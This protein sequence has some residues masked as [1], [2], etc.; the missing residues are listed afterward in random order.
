MMQY[1]EHFLFG[2]Y[3]YIGLSVFLIGSLVRFERGQYTWRSGSSQMLR[4]RQLRWGSNLFHI[5]I[6]FLFFG[7][8]VG[9][10]TPH[11][12]YEH[13]ITAGAKQMVAVVSG[14]T[15][16]V[17]CFIGLTLLLHRRLTDPRIRATSSPMDIAIL[18]VLWLQLVLGLITLPFSVQHSDGSTML[19]LSE[20]AQ[21]IVTFRGGAAELV[22]NVDWPFKLHLVLGITIFVLFP[23]SRLVH[24]WSAPVGY[25]F[26]S[27]QVVRRRSPARPSL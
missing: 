5:G 21:R 16:G 14:G 10:L 7:H 11:W 17:I 22:M 13:F 26:R 6:L 27:Y 18:L 9:L 2:I 20:W 3:P 23:F 25:V 15:A 8:L 4:A 19:A 12:L 1:V 24:I